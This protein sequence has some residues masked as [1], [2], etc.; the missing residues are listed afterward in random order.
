MVFLPN[1]ILEY[2]ASYADID[3]RRAMGY[4]PRK[5]SEEQR[6]LNLKFKEVI[7]FNMIPH[8]CLTI[9]GLSSLTLI[10]IIRKNLYEIRIT[11][12]TIHS[13]GTNRTLEIFF[14]K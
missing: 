9:C 7:C 6:S 10:K 1:D 2:I 12:T 11:K 4:K 8:I 13:N 3:S 14:L 5:L